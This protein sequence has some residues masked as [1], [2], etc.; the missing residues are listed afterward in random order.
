MHP[1]KY[2]LTDNGS[3]FSKKNSNIKHYCE[4]SITGNHIWTSVHHPQTMGKLSNMQKGLKRFLRHRLGN[5]TD[6]YEIDKCIKVYLDFYNN[7]AT[8]STTGSIPA[9]RYSNKVNEKWYSRLV[10]ELKLQAVLPIDHAPE[11]VT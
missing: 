11:G 10:K 3:Q 7:A 1:D 8:V 6:M 2:E 4:E 9:Q 5:S